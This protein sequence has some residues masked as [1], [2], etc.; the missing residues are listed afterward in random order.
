[1][2]ARSLIA[3]VLNSSTYVITSRFLSRSILH[4][5]QFIPAIINHLH[6]DL[7]GRSSAGKIVCQKDRIRAT[8]YGLQT[9]DYRPETM[10]APCFPAPRFPPLFSILVSTRLSRFGVIKHPPDPIH[11]SALD[12]LHRCRT[13]KSR[14]RF[15]QPASDVLRLHQTGKPVQ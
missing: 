12:H 4:H 7:P 3:L 13:I 6:G 15:L 5:Q 11:L 2:L 10:P 1:M 14:V 8:D 9:T